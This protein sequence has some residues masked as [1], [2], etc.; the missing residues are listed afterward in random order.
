M[1]SSSSQEWVCH[2]GSIINVAHVPI[3][4]LLQYEAEETFINV[5]TVLSEDTKFKIKFKFP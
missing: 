4:F 3:W 1:I 2:T 5:F